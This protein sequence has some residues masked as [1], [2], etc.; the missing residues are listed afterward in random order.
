MATKKAS[1]S[2]KTSTKQSVAT[3]VT[4]ESKTTKAKNLT[5]NEKFAALK[6]SALIAEFLGTFILTGAVLNLASNA[7]FGTVGI[8]LILAIAVVIFGA[9][10]GAHLNPAITIAQ[11][12]NRKVD[13]VKAWGYIVAQVLGAVLAFSILSGVLSATWDYNAKVM[14]SL[15]GAGVTSEVVE[16]AGGL[17][18]WSEQYG[19]VEAVASQLGVKNEAPK[20]FQTNKLAE[21]KEWVAFLTE[22][23]GAIIFGLGIGYAVFAKNKSSIETGLAVGL[24]LMA[25]LVIGGSTVILNPAIASI[26]GGFQWVNPFGAEAMAFWW[27]ILVYVVGT[28]IG[29][30]AGFTTYRLLQKDIDQK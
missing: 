4:S 7:N 21:G 23:L 28:T 11:Y 2:N 16:K 13:G 22:I 30:T 29:M 10:S 9:V 24:S 5:I 12:V 1:S 27:S 14:T 6:P 15:E 17:E 25:G 20:V 3:K 8:A 19:G 26:I 18:K